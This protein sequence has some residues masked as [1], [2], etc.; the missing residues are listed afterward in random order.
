MNE[1]TTPGATGTDTARGRAAAR[2][3]E[4]RRAAARKPKARPQP[5]SADE[6]RRIGTEITDNWSRPPEANRL[7]LLEVDPWRVHAYWH[8]AEA[9]LA[10]A[11]ACLPGGG[12][13]AVLVL[14]FTDLS[15]HAEGTAQPHERFDIEV[16]EARNNWYVGL[17]RD[18]KHYSAELGLRE[19]GGGFITLARSNEVATPRGRPAPELEFR[20]LEVRAPR[21]AQAQPAQDGAPLTDVLL[22]QLFPER[23]RPEDD[24]PLVSSEPSGVVLDEPPFPALP[25]A[26]DGDDPPAVG[27]GEKGV[28]AGVATRATPDDFPV[29]AADE[30][31]PYRAVARA[32]KAE[33]LAEVGTALPPVAADTIAPGEL[34]WE[35]QPLPIPP[36]A[37]S[38]V[39]EAGPDAGR[40]V[41][42]GAAAGAW[43]HI[44]L[45]GLLAGAVF[46]L[47]RGDS[48]VQA[49]AELLIHGQGAPGSPLMLFGLPV[50]REA[51]G[52]FTVRL[53]LPAGPEL[54]ALLGQLRG[55]Y[56][57]KDEG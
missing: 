18:A 20:H 27:G 31:D 7:T 43:P 50:Q 19:S 28:A 3:G 36:A 41:T 17:W 45:E 1:K 9:D 15:P 44:P 4:G 38:A 49:S 35:P 23:R 6:L 12:R 56:D 33:L 30:I 47:G 14:R 55:R 22:S 39:T 11:R 51:D 40:P 24:Y 32:A 54:A 16:R 29:I 57:G 52:R 10:T 42:V 5:F 21:A 53:P 26:A 25:E 37:E 8:V 34:E 48:P 2:G 46:S 13:D